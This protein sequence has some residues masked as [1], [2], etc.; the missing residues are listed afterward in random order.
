MLGRRRQMPLNFGV[1]SMKSIYL[2]LQTV[3]GC[4][5]LACTVLGTVM[6]TKGKEPHPR[7]GEGETDVEARVSGAQRRMKRFWGHQEAFSRE[8]QQGPEGQES[9]R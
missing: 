1:A 4:L 6:Y 9:V 7:G 2:C 3:V 5:F 8:W